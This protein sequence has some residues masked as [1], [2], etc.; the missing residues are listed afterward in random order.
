MIMHVAW[1]DGIRDFFTSSIN[2]M[3]AYFSDTHTWAYEITYWGG[4]AFVLGFLFKNLGKYIISA[5]LAIWVAL[6]L[7]SEIGLIDVHTAELLKFF[8]VSSVHQILPALKTTIETHTAGTVA[9]VCGFF[10]GWKLG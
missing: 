9:A 10:I 1:Y 7:F 5:A 6:F 8:G 4:G 3:R 2:S